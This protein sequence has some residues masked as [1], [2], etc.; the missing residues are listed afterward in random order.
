MMDNETYSLL[1]DQMIERN[2][3]ENRF[4]E[5]ISQLVWKLHTKTDTG[6]TQEIYTNFT[7]P[8]SA[9]SFSKAVFAHA[10]P[11]T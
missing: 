5:H 1:L 9:F 6:K 2:R 7:W 4:L 10:N 8:A 11:M 3:K